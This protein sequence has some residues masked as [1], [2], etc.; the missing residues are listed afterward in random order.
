MKRLQ[1]G[2]V[3]VGGGIAGCTLAILLA[4]RGVAV[5]VVERQRQWQFHGSGIFVYSNG[6]A[7]LQA[8]G[9]LPAILDSGFAI[10]RGRNVY[11]DQR[12]EPIT[13]T[14]YPHAPGTGLPPILGIR[15]AEL[16]RI[17]LERMQALQVRVRLD[18][19]VATLDDP[20]GGDAVRL[21]LADGTALQA[22][23]VIGADGVRSQL[24]SMLFGAVEPVDTGFGVWRSIHRRPAHL[25]DKIM[26]MGVG[27]RLG[28]MPISD[29]QLYVYATTN[30]PGH[31]FYE[32][33]TLHRTMREKF[34]EFEGPAR[35]FLDDLREPTQAFYTAVE[36]VR[37]PLPWSRGRVGL[38][39][40]AAHASTPFMGQGGA[41]AMEDSIVLADML[42]RGDD[43][44]Q[45]L[46][47]FGARRQPK[48]AFVQEAS[49]R[50]GEAGGTESADSCVAR[51]ERMRAHAQ[52]DVDTFYRRLY[53]FDDVAAA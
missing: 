9:V 39:G 46:A 25:V 11:Y 34:A 37:L 5:T 3:I 23:L 2:V 18:C 29:E 51:N 36:E 6:L 20:A 21:Q 44:A 19:T 52:A 27:K 17:L 49:R 26:M 45:T 1:H 48:C 40:D 28:I 13:E 47:A 22:S 7:A 35:A 8:I 42:A 14:F 53:A 4:A 24:R 41:M 15:R 38:I 43:V 12:G 33:A 31:P 50:V 32:P 16:H 30:E 10:A